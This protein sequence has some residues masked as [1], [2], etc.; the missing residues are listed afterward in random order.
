MTMPARSLYRERFQPVMP[1]MFVML[2]GCG[3][4]DDAPQ[5]PPVTTLPAPVSIPYTNGAATPSNP[6]AYWSRI[7]SETI[8]LPATAT[9]TPEERRP[10]FLVDMATVHVAIYD[11]VIAIAGTHRPFAATPVTSTTGAS[12]EAAAA[13]AAFGVLTGLFPSRSAQYQAAY[14]AAVAALPAG[15]ATNRG[16]AIGG[17]VATRILALRADDGRFTPVTYTPGTGPGQFRGVNPAAPFA[18][19]IKP[20]TMTSASQF[21][22]P[23]PPPLGST[24][25]AADV[26]ETMALGGSAST[27]RTPEQFEAAR[28]HTESPPTLLTRNYRQFAVEGRPTA[29]NARLMAMLWVAQADAGIACFDSKYHYMFWRPLTA[30][31]EADTDGNAATAPDPAWAASLP[32]PNH[33][34]YPSAHMC[35]NVAASTVLKSYYGTNQ[36]V[37]TF[38]STVTATTR[39]YATPDDML[40]EIVLARITGAMHFR[41]SNLQGGVLGDNVA[42]WVV[43]NH[44]RPVN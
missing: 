19:F 7:A 28:F 32:T 10:Y 20:F 8:N 9:G 43:A 26:N 2:A 34:E 13:G 40:A 23:P 1:L 29:D 38:G 16:L 5:P 11:A 6:V 30:I 3:S 25:Y 14:D 18:P 21:R 4:S 12:Q 15:D 22:L 36:I 17:E 41:N 27:Q 42:K 24:L 33:P 44:F 37:F 31:R 39:T 35:Q